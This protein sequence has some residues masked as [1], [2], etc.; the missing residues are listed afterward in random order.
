MMLMVVQALARHCKA[1]QRPLGG[2]MLSPASQAGKSAVDLFLSA[3][4]LALPVSSARARYEVPSVKQCRILLL[5]WQCS[6]ILR[7]SWQMAA[8]S[9]TTH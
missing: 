1:E 2:R 6:R 5:E 3:I 8:E 9:E 4:G 7:L